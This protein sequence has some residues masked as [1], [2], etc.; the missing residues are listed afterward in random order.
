M[1]EGAVMGFDP[2]P[3]PFF[4]CYMFFLKKWLLDLFLV[5]Y[6]F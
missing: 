2:S 3:P 5:L 6:I 1:L 4:F